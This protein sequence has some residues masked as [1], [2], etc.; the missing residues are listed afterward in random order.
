MATGNIAKKKY[1]KTYLDKAI[2]TLNIKD[3]N[4]IVKLKN[5]AD[6]NNDMKDL[7]SQIKTLKEKTNS[8]EA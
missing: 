3:D 7:T 8:D 2:K 5:I 4:D 1:I 6:Y